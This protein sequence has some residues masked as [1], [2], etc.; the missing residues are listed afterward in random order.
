M[1]A[2]TRRLAAILTCT[3]LLALTVAVVA[4]AFASPPA[5]YV[6]PMLERRLTYDPNIQRSPSVSGTRVVY[7]D[8]RNVNADVYLY[9]LSTNTERQL[10]TNPFNQ[11]NIDISGSK[12]VYQDDRNGN[13][14]V[15]LFDLSTNTE[16]QLT[17]DGSTQQYPKIDGTKVVYADL[18]NGNQDIY[19]YDLSTNTE[20]QIT[21]DASTQTVPDISGNKIVYEDYRNGNR[22]IYCYDLAK[23][24]ETQVTSHPEV[25][26]QP[27]VDG[28]TVAYQDERDYGTT[29]EIYAADLTT[30]QERRL[31]YSSIQQWGPAIS[32]SKV[33]YYDAAT[34]MTDLYCYDL[35]TGYTW[36]LTPSTAGTQETPCVDGGTIAFKDSRNGND[37]IYV[38]EL[39]VPKVSA[40]AP[41]VVSFGSTARLSG[42]LA[43]VSGIPMA[44]RVVTLQTSSDGLSWASIKTTTTNSSGGY[45]F[46]SPALTSARYLRANFKEYSGYLSA[47]SSAR[48]VKPKVYLTRASFGR[49]T[50]SLR[51]DLHGEGLPQAA[52]HGLH[53][54]VK[55][56]VYR[57]SS[58][59][60]RYYKTY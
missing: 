22:D 5:V 36:P 42:T 58:G 18:R 54:P 33:V 9:D 55:I 59:K 53:H 31:T 47:Q 43:S 24:T 1:T 34:G 12:V 11:V 46:T 39:V 51:Q 2:R 56:A 29:Y 13:V 20:R 52:A 41:S 15:F 6:S 32:G 38:G 23:K 19:L 49:K 44:G 35:E 7:A 45:A 37:E 27:R 3:T 48:L 25:Q 10:T 14:D 4:P 40:G 21:N 16:R 17:K 26:S 57:Y 50:L 8:Y 60:Y 28:N 30:L